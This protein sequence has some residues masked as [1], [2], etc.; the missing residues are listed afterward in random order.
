V[1]DVQSGK[2]RQDGKGQNYKHLKDL[3]KEMV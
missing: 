1:T 3:A 2:E